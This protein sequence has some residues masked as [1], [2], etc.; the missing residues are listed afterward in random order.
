VGGVTVSG[1]AARQEAVGINTS[2]NRSKQTTNNNRRATLLIGG[3]RLLRGVQG[4]LG[5]KDTE[6]ERGMKINKTSPDARCRLIG[7]SVVEQLHGGLL[8]GKEK[9]EPSGFTLCAF[10]F[11]FQNKSFHKGRQHCFLSIGQ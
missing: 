2:S 6:A 11:K 10:I 9:N 3:R 4:Q 1:A 7:P 5:E 8:A